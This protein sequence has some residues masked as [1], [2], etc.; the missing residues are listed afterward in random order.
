LERLG[1]EVLA[2]LLHDERVLGAR[3]TIGKPQLLGGAT[4]AVT[5][6]AVRSP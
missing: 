4:P 3:V 2:L 1:E 6:S 5:V